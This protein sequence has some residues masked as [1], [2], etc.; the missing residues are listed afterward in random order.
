MK[1]NNKYKKKRVGPAFQSQKVA[2]VECEIK[3]YMS[4]GT[5]VDFYLGWLQLSK[6]TRG[7]N[8]VLSSLVT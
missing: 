5:K 8:L 3:F 7:K 4:H 6:S 1:K 2:T